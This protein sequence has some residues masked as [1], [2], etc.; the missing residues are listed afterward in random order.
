MAIPLFI[1]FYFITSEKKNLDPNH[2]CSAHLHTTLPAPSIQLL[3]WFDEIIR[4]SAAIYVVMPHPIFTGKQEDGE[5][6]SQTGGSASSR[7]KGGAWW[8]GPV[9]SRSVRPSEPI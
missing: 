3:T 4:F 7:L 9:A 2:L 1:R 6:E 5:E 8:A